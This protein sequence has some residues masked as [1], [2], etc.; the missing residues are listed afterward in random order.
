[1]TWQTVKT[2]LWSVAGGAVVWWIVLS[3]GLGWMSAG[4]AEKQA[5]VRAEA[6]VLEVLAPICVARF[7]QDGDREHKL[8]ALKK[9]NSWMR[10]DFVIKQGWATMP[11]SEKSG[12][13]MARECA[14]RILATSNS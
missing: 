8:E 4:S 10:K 3:A 13:R 14:G 9:E 7:Q 5:G 11:N 12:S 1:M 2:V 6:A